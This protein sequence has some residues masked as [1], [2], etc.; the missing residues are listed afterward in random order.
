M[1]AQGDTSI[2]AA[3][4]FTKTYAELGVYD[5]LFHFSSRQA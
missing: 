1:L 3:T 5:A 2:N 4:V